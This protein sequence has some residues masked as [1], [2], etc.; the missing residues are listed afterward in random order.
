MNKLDPNRRSS[1]ESALSA[2]V[3]TCTSHMVRPGI[4]PTILRSADLRL[5]VSKLESLHLLKEE[6]GNLTNVA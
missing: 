2:V 5:Q 6:P 3:R 1:L 4:G